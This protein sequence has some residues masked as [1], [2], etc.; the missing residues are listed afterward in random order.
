MDVKAPP[1]CYDRLSGVAA[2]IGA[3]E[4]SI[5]LIA[6]SGVAHEF[7]TTVVRPLLSERDILSIRSMIPEG[8]PHILQ[9]FD[10]EH[11]LDQGLRIFVPPP[12]VEAAAGGRTA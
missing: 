11:A 1:E 4:E 10:P 3:V 8:S 7:R 12:G 6:R 5:G 9:T 2:P